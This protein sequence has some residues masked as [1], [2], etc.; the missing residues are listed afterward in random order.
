LLFWD[1]VIYQRMICIWVESTAVVC[2]MLVFAKYW[3]RLF[4]GCSN[5]VFGLHNVLD[6]VFQA[7]RLLFCCQGHKLPVLY[8]LVDNF[9]PYWLLLQTPCRWS[10]CPT[11]LTSVLWACNTAQLAIA[12]GGSLH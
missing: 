10:S 2:I 8:M 5:V 12:T 9:F 6:I 1:W 3:H 4:L 11:I 7:Y